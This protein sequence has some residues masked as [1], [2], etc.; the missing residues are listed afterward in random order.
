MRKYTKSLTKIKRRLK[1]LSKISSDLCDPKKEDCLSCGS[2][3]NCFNGMR[4]GIRD[5]CDSII[6]CLDAIKT[7]E[8]CIVDLTGNTSKKLRKKKE[9]E[10]EVCKKFDYY[11]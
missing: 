2:F 7:L 6:Y 1:D 10:D 8:E 4:S 9:V 11:S 5:V 3:M